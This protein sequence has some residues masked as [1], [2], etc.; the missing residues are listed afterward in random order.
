MQSLNGSLISALHQYDEIITICSC[1]YHMK[2]CPSYSV[3][4]NKILEEKRNFPGKTVYRI[5]P[6]KLNRNLTPIKRPVHH[7]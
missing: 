3:S 6:K 2:A 5:Q 4:I 1:V 7:R